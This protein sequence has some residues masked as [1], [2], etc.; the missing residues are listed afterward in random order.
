MK[1]D[2]IPWSE[3]T[4][5]KSWD[6]YF[7]NICKLV[8]TRSKDKSTKHGCVIVR[9]DRSIA[10]TGYN[11]FPRGVDDSV[12]SRYEKPKKYLYTEHD[13]RNAILTA[14]RHGVTLDG[15]TVYLTGRPCAA[16]VRA[17]LQSGIVEVVWDADSPWNT[18]LD[19]QENLDAGQ[20]MMDERGIKARAVKTT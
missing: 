2:R 20:E 15:C 8:A 3:N 5:R 17:I 14:S 7:L 6:E 19:Q 4:R 11:G 18:R 1:K 9:S 13:A 10:S 16:C 12:E